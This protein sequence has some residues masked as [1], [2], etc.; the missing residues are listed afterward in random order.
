M[1][2][3]GASR[4]PMG[5]PI[6]LPTFFCSFFLFVLFSSTALSVAI[7]GEEKSDWAEILQTHTYGHSLGQGKN[8]FGAVIFH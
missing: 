6:G 3:F 5:S 2:I 7:C 1:H 4:S 8:S